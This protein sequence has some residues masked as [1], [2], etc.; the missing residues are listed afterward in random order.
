MDLGYGENE[1]LNG[2]D[3]YFNTKSCSELV[4]SSFRNSFLAEI[5]GKHSNMSA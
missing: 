2:Y 5:I 4:T 3:S 1:E